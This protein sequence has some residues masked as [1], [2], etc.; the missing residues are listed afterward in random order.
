MS[1][2]CYRCGVIT[3][4]G[5]LI[6]Y[7]FARKGDMRPC[8]GSWQ[9]WRY[10]EY[11]FAIVGQENPEPRITSETQSLTEDEYAFSFVGQ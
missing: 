5:D 11:P 2:A 3:K 7:H 8:G 10:L 4:V 9:T 6:G 1:Y